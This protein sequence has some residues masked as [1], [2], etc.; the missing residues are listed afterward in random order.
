[1]TNL[2]PELF[3]ERPIRSDFAQQQRQTLG[4]IRRIIFIVLAL[5]VFGGGAW[6]YMHFFGDS[7]A[8]AEIPTIQADG[9]VKQRPEHPGGIDIPHQ[10]EQVFQQL[11]SKS[12]DKQPGIEHLLPPPEA[13]KESAAKTTVTATASAVSVAKPTEPSGITTETKP[14]APLETAKP[15]ETPKAAPKKELAAKTATKSMVVG[16][17]P[18]DLFTDS[19]V[20]KPFLVQLGSYPDM[21]LA[22]TEM[23]KTQ[24]KFSSVL[25]GVNLRLTKA[26]LGAK[27]TYYRVQS[28]PLS[29]AQA[30]G[31]CAAL[32]AKKAPCIVVKQ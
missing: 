16:S 27:G 13:P 30:S 29:S 7:G 31:I 12:S 2:P 10:D 1:M 23:K 24:T 18:K 14:V 32:M 6:I 26:D 25:S 11:D 22:Q 19:A 20:T 8:P 17:I 15:V 5:V 4:R 3:A 21:K 28:E 9:Q